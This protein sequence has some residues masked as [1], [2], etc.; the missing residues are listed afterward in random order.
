MTTSTIEALDLSDLDLLDDEHTHASCDRCY[1][2]PPDLGVPFTAWCGRRAVR[3]RPGRRYVAPPDACA[4]CNDPD[5]PC[6][7]C[8]VVGP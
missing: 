5:L 8:G 4:A 1:P 2:E 6:A 3:L 7:T